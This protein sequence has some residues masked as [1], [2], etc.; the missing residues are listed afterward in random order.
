MR[1]RGWVVMWGCGGGGL[2]LFSLT[3]WAGSGGGGGTHTHTQEHTQERTRECCT[4]P[5]ATYPLRV[6]DFCTGGGGAAG[7]RSKQCPRA[8]KTKCQS[9]GTIW[10]WGS[11]TKVEAGAGAAPRPRKPGQ[12]Q[13]T[14]TVSTYCWSNPGGTSL[15]IRN[16][17]LF[18]ILFVRSFWRACSQFLLSVRNSAWGPFNRNSRGNPSFCRLG[19]GGGLRGTKIVNKHFVNKLAFPTGG[20]GR[21]KTCGKSSKNGRLRHG[22][23]SDARKCSCYTPL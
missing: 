7:S 1:G 5:L 4:Y 3:V 11:E 23:A 13:K 12:A 16:A 14:R 20:S 6:T 17:R 22:C 9:R 10:I 8:R 2:L 15:W 18:I 21:Q 19:G